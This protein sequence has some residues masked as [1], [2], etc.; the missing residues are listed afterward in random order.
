MRGAGLGPT[1]PSG[2]IWCHW[3]PW[4]LGNACDVPDAAAW[5]CLYARGPLE[6]VP[7][8]NEGRLRCSCCD[9]RLA[10]WG[11]ARSRRARSAGG[12]VRRVQPRRARCVGC[13]HTHVLLP[14]GLPVRRRDEVV[15]IGA[16]LVAQAAG[17]GQRRIA[18][19]LGVSTATVRGW[20]RGSGACWPTRVT[21]GWHRAE[22]AGCRL[23][24]LRA[25]E[26]VMQDRHRDI[27]LFRCSLI[28]EAA[29]HG[30][31]VPVVVRRRVLVRAWWS[32][33]R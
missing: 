19:R 6:H 25:L 4:R 22:R 5:G 28:R 11:R 23:L 18:E 20:L 29:T 1:S 13:E 15:V 32:R 30:L 7:P 2:L 14:D 17:D 12:V 24:S 31:R 26:A 10:P 33:R 8:Q 3:C 21:S 9:D 16:A 27:A